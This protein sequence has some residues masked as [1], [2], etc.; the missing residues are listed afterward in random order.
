MKKICLLAFCFFAVLAFICGCTDGTEESSAPVSIAESSASSTAESR[1]SVS[2]AERSDDRVSKTES[3]VMS[4][5][6]DESETS[7]DSSVAE[8]SSRA[9]AESSAEETSAEMSEESSRREES[10]VSAESSEP[11][12]SSRPTESPE[13]SEEST[14]P[15]ESSEESDESSLTESSEESTG[16]GESSADSSDETSS[17]T[18]PEDRVTYEDTLIR[19]GLGNYLCGV[20]YGYTWKVDYV[21]GVIVGEDVTVCTTQ[22]AYNAC[23]PDWSVTI[24]AEK[25]SDGTY[26]ALRDAIVSPGSAAGAGIRIGTNQIAI[27]VHSAASN[28]NAG[29]KN[30]K[31]KVVA[32]ATKAGDIFEIGDG[33]SSVYAV[34]P[35]TSQKDPNEGDDEMNGIGDAEFLPSGHLL[36]NGAAYSQ[37]YYSETW[38]PLY[39]DTY[40]SYAEA[41]PGVGIH[42]I[43]HPSSVINITNPLVRAMTNDQRAV[44]DRMEQ[45]IYGDV[46]FVNLGNI[47]EEHRGE[48]LYFKSDYHWTQ[49]GAYY[50]YR[51]FAE[52]VG[53]TPTPLKSFEEKIINDRFIGHTN[54]YAHDDRILS[55]YDTVY[56]YMP[57]KEHTYAVYFSDRSLY[58]V[59]DNCIQPSIDTYSCFLTGDQA[60]AV[61][62]VPENDQDKTAVVIKDSSANAFVPFLTEIYGNIVVIDPR[63]IQVDIRQ[64]VAEYG[65]DDIIF[66]ATASTSNGSAYRNYYEAMLNR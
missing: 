51:A 13:E 31:G 3:A 61:I 6:S 22:A 27:V 50:A 58:R 43:N 35:E 49:L 19:D 44:L 34:V 7:E 59:Y 62:N 20:P 60:F 21:N 29:Y 8:E 32:M 42:V 57:L 10:A 63:H 45:C 25:Q 39:A 12:E 11:T 4:D 1:E 36:Y 38:G 17:E 40:A 54:D 30:W 47:F 41:F 18:P 65:A 46:N 48:Y 23:N 5:E 53:L 56:A 2:E 9:S 16:Q 14:E 64:V 66:F 24:Y 15:A 33:W 37:A 28:P 55:F 26:I 52:S